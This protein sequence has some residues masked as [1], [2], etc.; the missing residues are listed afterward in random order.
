[1]PTPTSPKS[2]PTPPPRA[3]KVTMRPYVPPER[4][5]GGSIAKMFLVIVFGRCVWGIFGSER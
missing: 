3:P 5:T 2:T 1:M 4:R